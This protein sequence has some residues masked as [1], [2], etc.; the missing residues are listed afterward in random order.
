MN[1]SNSGIAG[2]YYW[3]VVNEAEV[4][5]ENKTYV[6][7]FTKTL[8]VKSEGI[9]T[10][11]FQAIDKAGNLSDIVSIT[12]QKDSVAPRDFTI[13]ITNETEEGFT[14]SAGTTDD[15][16]YTNDV[17]GIDYYEIYINGEKKEEIKAEGDN[18]TVTYTASG[19]SGDT[20]YTVN[21]R[22]FDKAG[23]MKESENMIGQTGGS[24]GEEPGGGEEPDPTPGGDEDP[25]K[26]GGGDEDDNPIPPEEQPGIDFGQ[27]P[28]LDKNNMIGKYVD[29]K[30][31]AGV[32]NDHNT[33]AGATNT[34]LLTGTDL[35]W[36]ILFIDNDKLTLI[37]DKPVHEGFN[38]Q[39]ADGYNNGVLLLN[40]AC[41][42]LYSNS[43][44]G[45]VGRS[46]NVGDIEK[47]SSY[48]GMKNTEISAFLDDNEEVKQ[49]G[50][51]MNYPKIFQLETTGAPN[52]KYGT[53]YGISEQDKYM[54]GTS[55]ASSSLKGRQSNYS[56]TMS[57]SY[58]SSNYLELFIYNSGTTVNLKDYWLASRSLFNFSEHARHPGWSSTACGSDVNYYLDF[59][60]F[61]KGGKKIATTTYLYRST[62]KSGNASY[63]IRPVVEIDLSKANVGATGDGSMY[64]PYS[65]TSKH[66]TK[67]EEEIDTSYAGKYV[68]YT[69]IEGV[70]TD[71]TYTAYSGVTNN[72]Q[73]V[74]DT[75]AEWRI[76]YTT[77]TTITLISEMPIH[78]GFN[79]NGA[80]GYNNGVL[81]LN[82]ACKELYSN[83]TIGAVGRNINT[84]DIEKISKFN[85]TEYSNYK[86]E[87]SLSTT[88]YPN[89]FELET[90][91]APGGTY[92]NRYNIMH[93]DEYITGNTSKTPL[94][95]KQTYYT[96]EITPS[97]V[98]STYLQILRYKP[99]TTEN[100]EGY[101]V[102]S[103]CAYSD[104]SNAYFR[105]F[106]ISEGILN[107]TDLYKSDLTS[108]NAVYALR[109]IIEI[110]RSK[111]TLGTS[112][113][114]SKYS[115]YTLTANQ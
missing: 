38:L 110:D 87:F 66:V 103:R 43:T 96:Y 82:N 108:T 49:R 17:S 115:P 97:Y 85:K 63:A 74:T 91:G 112:G 111:V 68:D 44:L 14:I 95:G 86:N 77:D 22:A 42:E 7:G 107:A 28:E 92:G 104:N 64:I 31:I 20:A 1:D 34:Q 67:P 35:Q 75:N 5:E 84:K 52:G 57:T 4:P 55:K 3:E 2:Y 105:M 69:P 37:S 81:L 48:S 54:K 79:L 71:H 89:I 61:Y 41:E 21:V 114:G 30:P 73:L 46:L 40:N 27:L 76:L 36:R 70:Y 15:T 99:G 29:Y 109:P 39:G 45:A 60:M 10:I 13:S 88:S 16:T 12:V 100:Y 53:N 83:N 50:D 51:I 93:Q 47:V 6:S 23:N 65:I 56:Y 9:R 58:V 78:S 113:D 8:T 24:G 62:N 59:K 101:W 90:T 11:N 80:D 106:Y 32:F 19:L 98:D 72:A 33:Y 102:S 94:N 25:D 18:P 26:P